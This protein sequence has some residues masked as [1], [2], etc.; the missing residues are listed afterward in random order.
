MINGSIEHHIKNR[1]PFERSSREE[2]GVISKYE[3]L[4]NQKKDCLGDELVSPF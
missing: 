2:S 3:R 4:N 1:S